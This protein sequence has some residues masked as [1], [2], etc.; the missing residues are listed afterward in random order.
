MHQCLVEYSEKQLRE[1]EELLDNTD[2]LGVLQHM[3][4]CIARA[5]EHFEKWQS[6]KKNILHS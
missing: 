3:N 5:Y 2:S 6:K 1:L 4:Q